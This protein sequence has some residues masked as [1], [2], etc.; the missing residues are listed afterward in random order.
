MPHIYSDLEIISDV[1]GAIPDF[2]RRTSV[3]VGPCLVGAGAERFVFGT[4][5]KMNCVISM[6]FHG[7]VCP[8]GLDMP[9]IGLSS[10]KKIRDL[11]SDLGIMDRVVDVNVDDLAA[12]LAEKT[13]YMSGHSQEIHAQNLAINRRLATD[14]NGFLKNLSTFMHE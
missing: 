6:R 12:E 5:A 3:T 4:Y 10:Y 13:I 14:M 11:Y 8:I 9:T 1:L 7:N 2:L